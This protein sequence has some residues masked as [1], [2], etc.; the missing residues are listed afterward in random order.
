M[1]SENSKPPNLSQVRNYL[2]FYPKSGVR[3]FPLVGMTGIMDILQD[4]MS[5]VN[6]MNKFIDFDLVYAECM[7][8]KIQTVS[9]D[10]ETY[11]KGCFWGDEKP[12]DERWS[13]LV[14]DSYKVDGCEHTIYLNPLLNR[15]NIA[16]LLNG[17][18]K[19]EVLEE[20]IYYPL[21]FHEVGHIVYRHRN[22]ALLYFLHQC[23]K[24]KY[25]K[26]NFE[27]E[28]VAWG[29][30]KKRFIEWKNQKAK[31]EEYVFKI[32]LK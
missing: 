13:L 25:K 7:K 32:D 4:F 10:Y 2:R 14:T 6:Y 9:F 21:F 24:S 26:L 23:S 17:I 31:K 15:K 5:Y 30:A 1:Q 19:V 8:Y 27:Q 22:V 16:A 3:E 20:E 12:L 28:L 18:L 29:Y 11:S